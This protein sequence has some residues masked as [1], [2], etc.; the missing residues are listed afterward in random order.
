MIFSFF[1]NE[2]GNIDFKD[3]SGL[4]RTF[5]RCHKFEINVSMKLYVFKDDKKIVPYGFQ[6]HRQELIL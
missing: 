6:V 4:F 3:F 2:T 5:K 1:S